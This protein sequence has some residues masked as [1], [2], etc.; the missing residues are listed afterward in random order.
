MK[1]NQ[2]LEMCQKE[3][4]EV[5]VLMKENM[6]KVFEREGN[7]ARLEDRSEQLKNMASDFQ[8]TAHTVERKTRWE[9][10]RWYFIAGLIVLV[11][12]VIL[13]IIIA[14]QLA[15]GG[16]EETPAAENP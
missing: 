15:G 6:N 2:Q 5:T 7:L 12:V 3:A 1:A 14:T 13:I 9:K 11:I 4:E 10:W 8:K 16:G